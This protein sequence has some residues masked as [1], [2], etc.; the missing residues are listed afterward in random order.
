MKKNELTPKENE[1][2]DNIINKLQIYM[3]QNNQSLYNLATTIGF[4]YQPFYRLIK[5]RHTPNIS[6]LAM[7]ADHLN[8]SI[9]ELISDKIFVDIKMV[10]KLVDVANLDTQTNKVR[11]YIPYDD[12]KHYI[13]D[14]FFA[15]KLDNCK[16]SDVDNCKIYVITNEI[17]IDGEFIVNYQNKIKILNVISNSTKFITIESDNKEEKICKEE[18]QVIGKYVKSSLMFNPNNVYVQKDM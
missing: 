6:S 1:L 8:C 4:V 12:Y 14:K 15:V 2:I 9:E 17:N 10:D 16:M 7:I 11:I 5:S 13:H 18:F 3:D